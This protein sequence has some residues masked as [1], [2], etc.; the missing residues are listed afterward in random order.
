MA[1]T[2][3]KVLRLTFL[4]SLGK[5]A[6]FTIPNPRP[7]LTRSEVEDVMDTLI[8]KNIFLT[9]SGEIVAKRDARIIDTTTEDLYDPE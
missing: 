9:N 6:T 3:S 7:G 5:T 2:T 4:T 1:I 8:A